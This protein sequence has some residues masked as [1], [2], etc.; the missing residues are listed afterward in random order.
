[1]GSA[2]YLDGHMAIFDRQR[3]E[4]RSGLVWIASYPKSG[5]TWIRA[6]LHNLFK[7]VAGEQDGQ[8]INGLS[9]FTGSVGSKNLYAALLGFRPTDQQ[10]EQIV[11]VRHQVQRHAADQFEGL[12]FTKTH[13]ALVVDRGLTT[14]NFEVTAGA[15]YIVRNPLDVA[16]SLAHHFGRS[17]DDAI[18]IMATEN[19][20]LEATDTQ[21]YELIG[22]WSQHV[23]SW[24]RKP[25][26]SVHVM[27]YE[28]ML[29]AP[30]K[31]FGTLARHLLMSPTSAQLADAIDRS[32]FDKL[33]AQEAAGGF[34][35]K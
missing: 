13:Q 18:A 11:A 24:T 14:I 29:A 20:E 4:P 22:S 15:I 6:F 35:E 27:R 28:D 33:R 5:N 12:V 9:R 26:P 3:V 31:T 1:V 17:V 19:I 34:R 2:F 21:V 16:I 23:R 30:D 7:V 32:A 10:R 25:H 8:D